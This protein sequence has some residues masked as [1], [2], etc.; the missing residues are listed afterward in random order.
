MA[1]R[2]RRWT[3]CTSITANLRR[4]S[5]A[6]RTP[7]GAIARR[8][9]GVSRRPMG[10]PS[11]LCGEG[12][13][14]NLIHV[15]PPVGYGASA[16]TAASLGPYDNALLHP[17]FEVAGAR[18]KSTTIRQPPSAR[19]SCSA[20]NAF[21]SSNLIA[22]PRER[23]RQGLTSRDRRI[24]ADRIRGSRRMPCDVFMSYTRLK[25]IDGN[26]TDLRAH[27]QKRLREE[28]K[29]DIRIF[30][31]T[32]I[33]AGAPWKAALRDE[34]RSARIFLCS[35]RRTGSIANIAILSLSLL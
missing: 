22:A 11:P 7:S 20:R 12:V 13:G 8:E 31:D 23:R 19:R 34:I 3:A 9:T 15:I 28:T 27:L 17:A 33:E 16:M 26:V 5:P 10:P 30:Q 29:R 14:R 6:F 35:Y 32:E 25:D 1:R 24:W 2:C 18:P 21:A 4:A